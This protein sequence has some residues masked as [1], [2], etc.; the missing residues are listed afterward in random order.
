MG[1]DKPEYYLHVGPPKTG[2]TFLQSMLDTHRDA[3]RSDGILYPRFQGN[4]RFMAALDARDQHTHRGTTHDA[5]GS[6]Q[7]FVD[8]TRDFNGK[9]A[10]SHELLS[11]PRDGK[12]PTALRA[13]EAYETHLVLTARDPGRQLPSCWQQGLRHATTTTFRD[14][15][16]SIRPDGTSTVGRRF[17]GQQLDRLLD[18]WGAHL[19][20]D[21][22]HIV[23]V[24]PRG[25]DPSAFWSRFCALLDVDADHYPVPDSVRPNP[26]LSV[27]QI[28]QLRR[29]SV[30]AQQRLSRSESRR[31][32]R[33]VYVRQIL[34]YTSAGQKPML[35]RYAAETAHGI[36]E[37]WIRAINK[38]GVDV[39][40]NVED[41]RPTHFCDDDPDAWNPNEVIDIGAEAIVDLLVRTDKAKSSTQ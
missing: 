20:A 5:G 16:A 27:A 22:I 2:T 7:R 37:T 8:R 36:A 23:V 15:L 29:V 34:P 12:P 17:E 31:L 13:L 9:V 4:G 33:Q 25:S 14:Y 3:L 32:I 6:W 30:V 39:V 1:H 26:S 40:G 38:H 11:A 18:V 28:E 21:H 10:F 19:P 24:P 35:P 41:L